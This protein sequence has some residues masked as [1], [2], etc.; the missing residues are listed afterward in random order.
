MAGFNTNEWNWLPSL[1]GL[2]QSAPQ[3]MPTDDATAQLMLKRR[4]AQADALRGAEMPQGQ[5]VSGHYVAPSWTQQLGTLFNAY[6]GKNL[7]EQVG[8]EQ[9]KL[10]QALRQQESEQ[11]NKYGEIAKE[12]KGAALRFALQSP[13]STLRNMAIERIKGQKLGDRKSTRLNS[14]H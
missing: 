8:Q 11:I 5:M 4:L 2:G 9:N 14:S 10:A 6:Q 7:S 3:E 12:D 13:S 1:P